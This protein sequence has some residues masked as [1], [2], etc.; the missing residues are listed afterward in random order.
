MSLTVNSMARSG[1]E[2][3]FI[4]LATAKRINSAADDAA[5]LAITEK[6]D[7]LVRGFDKGSDNAQ[8]MINLAKTAEGGLSSVSENLQRIRE[9]GIQ[10]QSG[11]L[12]NDDKKLIQYEVDGLLNNIKDVAKNTEFN[13]MK[14]L[15]GSF[16]DKLTASSPDGSGMNVTINDMSL[17]ALGLEGFNV[18]GSFDLSTIDSALDKVTAT[19]STLGATQNRLSSTI[20]SNDIT[21]LNLA[22]S[23]SRF[24]DADMGKTSID[25]NKNRVMLELQMFSIKNQMQQEEKSKLGLLMA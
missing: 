16:K 8:D 3:S 5:G 7:S 9:L 13:K 4:K 1:L 24:S 15:D 6:L 18:T 25:V 22:M 11:I 10:A 2:M 14:L 17:K 20:N 21:M 12:T 19:R 23:K